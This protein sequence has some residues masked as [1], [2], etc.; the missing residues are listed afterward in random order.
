[1]LALN[2]DELSLV[3]VEV[4]VILVNVDFTQNDNDLVV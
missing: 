2:L 4:E 3:W 1:M